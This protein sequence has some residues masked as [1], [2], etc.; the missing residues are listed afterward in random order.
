MAHKY[1]GSLL[2]LVALL[3]Q[4]CATAHDGNANAT[5]SLDLGNIINTLTPRVCITASGWCPY[6]RGAA[7]QPCKC[8][9][10]NYWEQGL[11]LKP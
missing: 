8:T 11:T 3:L 6:G 1:F 10:G 7:D 2:I 5:A 9:F 4:S